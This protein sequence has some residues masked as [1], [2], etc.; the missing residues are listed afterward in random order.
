[1]IFQ[2]RIWFLVS[3]H[4][5]QT[6]L[7]VMESW[8]IFHFHFHTTP[9]VA[10]DWGQECLSG[11]PYNTWQRGGVFDSQL[12]WIVNSQMDFNLELCQY[13]SVFL[14]MYFVRD[15]YTCLFTVFPTGKI[16]SCIIRNVKH[17]LIYL[18][19]WICYTG[20]RR[21]M[22]RWYS[23]SR[24]I[25]IRSPAPEAGGCLGMWVRYAGKWCKN[26]CSCYIC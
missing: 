17:L 9:V 23:Q 1:M 18:S 10:C 20:P 25:S 2:N 19:I 22:W 4:C 24:F 5:F 7:I 8:M 15:I 16:N 12:F 11:T 6:Q 26:S 14:L 3:S 21:T 13:K